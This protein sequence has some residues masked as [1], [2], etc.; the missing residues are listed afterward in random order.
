M[1]NLAIVYSKFF[2]GC[3]NLEEIRLIKCR[4]LYVS[5][6]LNQ[7]QVLESEGLKLREIFWKENT[8]IHYKY[9][10]S[11]IKGANNNLRTFIFI[12]AN[13]ANITDANE[14]LNALAQFCPNINLLAI[15]DVYACYSHLVKLFKSHPWEKITYL[16]LGSDGYSTQNIV[17]QK[18]PPYLP[19]SLRLWAELTLELYWN[20]INTSELMMDPNKKVESYW[21]E[22]NKVTV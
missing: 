5:N 4:N 22:R 9:I 13:R 12:S 6:Q 17:L 19:A 21:F 11:L 20:Y 15:M 1:L 8:H 7:D 2:L 3:K 18:L 14:I 10:V 16:T